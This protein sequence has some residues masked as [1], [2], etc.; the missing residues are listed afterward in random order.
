[1]KKYFNIIG[2]DTQ[3]IKVEVFYDKGSYSY[4]TYESSQRGYYI[5][6]MLLGVSKKNGYISEE[7]SLFNSGYKKLIKPVNRASKKAE[8]E[9]NN[10]MMAYAKPIIEI[11]CKEKNIKIG[12]EWEF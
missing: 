4:L 8:N 9:V 2:S 6:V 7:Y 1:M 12:D 5:S 10:H 3:K 11:M